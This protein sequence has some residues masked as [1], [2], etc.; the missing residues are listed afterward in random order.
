[1]HSELEFLRTTFRQNGYSDRQIRRALNPPARVSSTP[2]KP[3][4]VAFLP[5]VSKTFNRISRLPS[6][7]NIKSVGL[8]RKMIPSFL[9][10]VMDDLGLM[11]PDVYGVPCECGQVCIG[12]TGRSIETRFKEH[13]RHISLQHPDKSVV[14]E[15]RMNLDHS[16]QLQDTYQLTNHI[17]GPDDQGGH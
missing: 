11:T 8:P 13:Q 5:Y 14:A 4:S 9:R 15:H 10:P 2:E 12:Q 6:R 3:A 1:L 7:H 17:H 16:I